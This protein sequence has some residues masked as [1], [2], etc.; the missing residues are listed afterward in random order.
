MRAILLVGWYWYGLSGF[1]LSLLG[2]NL[3]PVRQAGL[4]GA[5][6]STGAWVIPSKYDSILPFTGSNSWVLHKGRW[7]VIDARGKTKGK[8][9]KGLLPYPFA[10]GTAVVQA[11][12]G[13]FGL[14]NVKSKVV[15]APTW[16]GI[17]PAVLG[18]RV[19]LSENDS[20]A[21][22]T[23]AGELLTPPRYNLIEPSPM[24]IA[25]LRNR[26]WGL[27]DANGR[28]VTQ[29]RYEAI[30]PFQEVELPS[31]RLA[32]RAVG[33]ANGTWGILDSIGRF[34]GP[35]RFADVD[36]TGFSEEL[37]AVRMDSLW[38]FVNA[39]GGWV[40]RPTRYG[41]GPVKE[42]LAAARNKAGKWGFI[43]R[44]GNWAVAPTY[45][46]VGYFQE[47]LAPVWRNGELGFINQLGRE[48]IPP[49]FLSATGFENGYA[50]AQLRTGWGVIDRTGY[51]VVS[52][53]YARLERL[54][55]GGW[56]G[57][58]N[59]STRLLSPT[60]EEIR[61]WENPASEGLLFRS[62]PTGIAV[63]QKHRSVGYAR[64]NA[65]LYPCSA[66]L[67]TRL[68]DEKTRLEHA[69]NG[70]FWAKGEV[71]RWP[72]QTVGYANSTPL[73][74]GYGWVQQRA[75][76]RLFLD[77][78]AP[79]TPPLKSLQ[80][81][82]S[83]WALVQTF[84]GQHTGFQ[85]DAALPFRSGIARVQLDGRW[86]LVDTNAYV[87]AQPRH[88][89]LQPTARPDF[90]IGTADDGRQGV[91]STDGRWLIA[92][93]FHFVFETGPGVFEVG[94]RQRDKATRQLNPVSA[95]VNPFGNV[96]LERLYG[97]TT[98][99]EANMYSLR[100]GPF[101]RLYDQNLAPV[102]AT[103]YYQF[104]PFS[105]GLAAAERLLEWG[106][107]DRDG[108]WIIEPQFQ[109]ARPFREGTAPVKKAG[110]WGYIDRQANWVLE[111]A[112]EDALA[113]QG[114]L[115]PARQNGRWGLIDSSG[116]F[117]LEPT[118]DEIRPAGEGAWHVLHSR[119][120]Y[121]LSDSGVLKPYVER[122]YGLADSTG[123]LMLPPVYEWLSAVRGGRVAYRKESSEQLLGLYDFEGA[124]RWPSFTPEPTAAPPP[125]ASPQN[126][127]PA[128]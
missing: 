128:E 2:Q 18:Y 122:T 40:V 67:D 60:G 57:F 42:S 87:M 45:D 25:Y 82:G 7:K 49:K 125:E 62:T 77:F 117:I 3:V 72:N 95:F 85:F 106:Y 70:I 111:P 84:V 90:Y 100:D 56:L 23:A 61:R 50:L 91:L 109:D 32:W 58:V 53:K 102:Q 65:S 59:N 64:L 43:D 20:V 76:L 74:N 88:A 113:F 69:R 71:F 21:L 52:P 86:G 38:G 124:Q 47:A 98:P 63:L 107:L 112:Y 101:W 123:K 33:R 31:G 89:W 13:R 105:E 80:L 54:P 81:G 12:D 10:G 115:A 35:L 110:Q 41:L 16:E 118:Y 73:E 5:I 39:N 30:L 108:R 24:G 15:L 44:T 79:G 17:G 22:A 126:E 92:P 120:S 28:E 78:T 9:E 93:E 51:P 104:K 37:L 68:M 27:M 26:F 29:P 11:P 6:D 96:L 83:P 55:N 127:P 8:L 94:M 46:R 19:L 103:R 48:V 14:A 1:G 97:L 75:E 34:V 119:R 4:W 99:V 116:S 66:C 121:R 36:Q 114:P